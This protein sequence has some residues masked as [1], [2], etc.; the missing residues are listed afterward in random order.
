MS[1]YISSLLT[2][3]IW[4][5]SFIFSLIHSLLCLF[6]TFLYNDQPLLSCNI[7]SHSRTCSR[8]YALHFVLLLVNDLH[9]F[10]LLLFKLSTHSLTRS[11]IHSFTHS[12]LH[13][14]LLRVNNLHLFPLPLYLFNI[15]SL[16]RLL[17][18]SQ[19]SPN[20]PHL[21]FPSASF[22]PL[23]HHLNV[24][25][26]ELTLTHALSPPLTH[27]NHPNKRVLGCPVA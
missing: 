2:R 1:I 9:L 13:S 25:N 3:Q 22:S 20:V 23:T 27:R 15:H 4:T 10:F 5:H 11:F 18:Q 26:D 17:I 7:H 16:T 12:F 6:F 8:T 14:V 21:N 24:F 19:S